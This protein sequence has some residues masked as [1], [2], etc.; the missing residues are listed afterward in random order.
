MNMAEAAQAMADFGGNGFDWKDATFLVLFGG[1]V[2]FIL[3]AILRLSSGDSRFVLEDLVIDHATNRASDRKMFK[4]GA[5]VATTF[6]VVYM[7]IKNALTE[8]ALMGY[9]VLWVLEDV[10][11]AARGRLA[12]PP[13]QSSKSRARKPPHTGAKP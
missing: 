9:G 6:I 10:A 3:R 4:A 8:W 1:A 13:E 7:T 11:T 2:T 5:F 12:W